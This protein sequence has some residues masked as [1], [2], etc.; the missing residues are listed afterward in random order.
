MAPLPDFITQDPDGIL[1]LTGHRIGLHDLIPLYRNGYSP[2]MLAAHFPT[3]SLALIHKTIAFY[4]ENAADMDRYVQNELQLSA[5]QRSASTTPSLKQ[6][7]DRLAK[8]Q[9]G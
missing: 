1:R 3:L 5:Q 4:L 7:R 6:L 2:E 8:T 9:K